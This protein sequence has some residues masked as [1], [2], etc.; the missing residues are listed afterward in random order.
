MQPPHFYNH[1]EIFTRTFLCGV[2]AKIVLAISH[3]LVSH[4]VRKHHNHYCDHNWL[5]INFWG[6]WQ[7]GSR[8]DYQ[9]SSFKIL[10]Y[11]TVKLC[12][13]S[14]MNPN[15]NKPPQYTIPY[16]KIL[17]CNH[18]GPDQNFPRNSA[19]WWISNCRYGFG[20]RTQ[21]Y[22]KLCNLLLMFFFVEKYLDFPWMFEAVT[23]TGPSSFLVTISFSKNDM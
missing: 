8:S 15:L 2:S 20:N 21:R 6:W 12:N 18:S 17:P 19:M 3:R 7:K 9:I 5:K 4:T 14:I 16:I 23:I 1:V 13:I 22:K 11:H 10:I